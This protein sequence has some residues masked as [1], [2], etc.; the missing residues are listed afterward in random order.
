MLENNNVTISG[1]ILPQTAN[2]NVTLQ[3]KINSDSWTTI[4]TVKTQADGR[5]EYNWTT[6]TG[7]VIP[8]Q[9]SWLGN[10]QYNG[11]MSP[12]VTIL[13]LPVFMVLLTVALVLAVA[14]LVLVFF[15]TRRKTPE[16]PQPLESALSPT[17]SIGI[18]LFFWQLL[19]IENIVEDRFRRKNKI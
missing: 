5:Y 1:Q 6:A 13:I 12:Q 7:G 14:L 2:E 11:A 15:K 19:L 10:R 17:N 18:R 3:A 4:A 8:I 16:P 9:A